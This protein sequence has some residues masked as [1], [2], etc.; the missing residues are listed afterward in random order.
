MESST[1]KRIFFEA[2]QL[3]C[4]RRGLVGEDLSV[5]DVDDAVCILSDVGLVRD[6]DDGVAFGV[7]LI[8][9]RQYPRRR[10]WNRG[11]LSARRRG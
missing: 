2:R 6:E 1:R 3:S 9:Q 11:C 7:K 8:K 4:A 10:F 5:A